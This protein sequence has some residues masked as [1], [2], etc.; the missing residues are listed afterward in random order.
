MGRIDIALAKTELEQAVSAAE[1]AAKRAFSSLRNAAEGRNSQKPESPLLKLCPY[2][3]R[4]Q[5]AGPGS[6]NG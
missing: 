5:K 2:M 6:S 3:A 1:G 4:A